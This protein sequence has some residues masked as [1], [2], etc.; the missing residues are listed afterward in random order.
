MVTDCPFDCKSCECLCRLE[1]CNYSAY[2]G[3]NVFNGLLNIL[4]GLFVG[5]MLM[6]VLFYS[7]V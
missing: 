1:S 7:Y 6:L 5:V 2:V 4:N 3:L